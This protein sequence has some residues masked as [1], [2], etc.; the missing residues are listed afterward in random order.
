L[1]ES[2]I[3]FVLKDENFLTIVMPL[4]IWYNTTI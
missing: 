3:P 1:N 2:N 4:N